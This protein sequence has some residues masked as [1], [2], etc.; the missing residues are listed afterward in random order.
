[1]S[2]EEVR[3]KQAK[4][5]AK[6][7][8]TD[9]K[10]YIRKIAGEEIQERIDKSLDAIKKEMTEA[11]INYMDETYSIPADVVPQLPH[12]KGIVLQIKEL[13][14]EGL[15][16]VEGL[17]LNHKNLLTLKEIQQLKKLSGSKWAVAVSAIFTIAILFRY[18]GVL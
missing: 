15:K 10:K 4:A 6:S 18:L 13:S 8:Q 11:I 1:M 2:E 5:V 17:D 7:L 12:I 16:Q 9:V 14:A 3:I